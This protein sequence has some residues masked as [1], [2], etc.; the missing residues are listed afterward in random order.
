MN[1]PVPAPASAPEAEDFGTLKGFLLRAVMWLPLAFFLWYVLRWGV[2]SPPIKLSGWLL[3]MW[4]PD[5][6]GSVGQDFEKLSFTILANLQGMSD[7]PGKIMEVQLEDNALKYCYGTALY[8]GLVM[9]TPLSWARTFVQLIVGLLFIFP[10]QAFG[11]I[12]EV[13]KTLAYDVDSAVV[14]GLNVEGYGAI[15][16]QAGAIAQQAALTSLTNHGLSLDAV[17]V[18]YQF[19]YLILPAV[20]PVVV[21]ILLNRRFIEAL[22]ASL[23]PLETPASRAGQ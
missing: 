6:V 12:G 19:G 20:A 14:A 18:I 9:A 23:A 15:A 8:L 4:M 22:G 13:L 17:G 11:L 21:W 10:T 2:V 16:T 1:T 7:A 3:G 5:A